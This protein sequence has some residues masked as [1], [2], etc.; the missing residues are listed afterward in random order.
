MPAR[1]CRVT[2]HQALSSSRPPC[3]SPAAR[4]PLTSRGNLTTTIDTINGMPSTSPT[5]ATPPN[6]NS[7]KSSPS[8]RSPSRR[9]ALPKSSAG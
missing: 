3:P 9:R 4:T 5:P 2:S 1:D 8:A 6:G 7:H